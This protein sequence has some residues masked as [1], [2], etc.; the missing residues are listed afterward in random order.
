MGLRIQPLDIEI[1][2]GNPFKHDLLGR[3]ERVQ[4]LTRIIENL[5]GPCAISVDAAWGAGKT[6]FLRMWSQH[7]RDEGF[8]VVQ[9]NAWETD[10]TGE[11]FVALSSE[12]T[13]GL[14]DWQGANVNS[15]VEKTKEAAK[16]I[17][18]WVVPGAVRLAASMIPIAG[19]EVS[20]V[21]GAFAERLFEEY[22]DAQQSVRGFRTDIQSMADA[23]WE[24][25]DLKP[26]VVFIDELDRCRPSYA[27]ELLETCKHIFS[28]DHA[29]FVLA[30]N[31]GELAHS[32]R[33]LYGAK[34]GAE[35]YLRRFFDLEFILPSPDRQKFIEDMLGSLG[36]NEL[37]EQSERRWVVSNAPGSARVL[38]AFL[39][40]SELSLRTIGQTIHRLGL[41]LSSLSDSEHGTVRLLTILTILRAVDPQLYRGFV[42]GDMTDKEITANLMEKSGYGDLKSDNVSELVEAVVIE[43]RCDGNDVYQATNALESR[44]PL[45]WELHQSVRGLNQAIVF[46]QESGRSN[47]VLLMVEDL[48]RI[49]SERSGSLGLKE[50]VNRIELVSAGLLRD[51]P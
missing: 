38:S 20:Q 37:L 24:S 29:V 2:P 49:R 30:V 48:Y 8:P 28:V 36:I 5:D 14:K 51:S 16:S 47:R 43:A 25:S 31:Q 18:R 13:D 23:L 21:A 3:R 6:T 15:R 50:T 11:P 26:L 44:A 42:G 45:L 22:P 1:P 4:V 40:Q 7:L 9:F 33:V 12:I 27:V 39:G 46:S 10:F 17:A 32:V 34:F 19:S 41:V 35:D